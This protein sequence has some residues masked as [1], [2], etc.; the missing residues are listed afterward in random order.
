MS[1]HQLRL[2]LESIRNRLE[3]HLTARQA[4][5][6]AWAIAKS[7]ARQPTDY[8]EKEDDYEEKE[9]GDPTPWCHVCGAMDLVDCDCLPIAENN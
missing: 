5:A 7:Y 1:E 9:D 8:E 3:K 6:L 2:L 4:E